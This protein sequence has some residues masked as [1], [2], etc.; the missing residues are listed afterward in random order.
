MTLRLQANH[1]LRPVDEADV[2]VTDVTHPALSAPWRAHAPM[3]RS[4]AATYSPAPRESRTAVRRPG[5]TVRANG[6]SYL[7]THLMEET[8][9]AP[10]WGP[11][12]TS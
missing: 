4:T 1:R 8:R 6:R 9:K 12:T 3:R 10:S 5:V 7:L 11:S 2:P